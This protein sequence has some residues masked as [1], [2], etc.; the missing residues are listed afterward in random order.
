[1]AHDI[2][3]PRTKKYTKFKTFL[4][5]L[6]FLIKKFFYFFIIFINFIFHYKKKKIIDIQDYI[7]DTRF[8]NYLFYS[9]K[10]NYCFSYN[11]SFTLVNFVKKIGIKNFI[12]HSVPNILL[13]KKK[14]IKFLVNSNDK[15]IDAIN[16]N[17]N[18]FGNK[19]DK[20]FFYM[21]YYMYPKIYNNKYSEIEKLKKN[22]KTIRILFSG[23]TNEEVY[24]KF[25][26]KYSD[27][28]RLLNRVEI[29]NYIID[30]FKDKVY[31]LKNYTDIK[32]IDFF[33]KKIVLSINNKL[34]KKSNTNLTTNEHLDLI[35][36]SNFF[37]TAP[38]GDMPLCHHLIESIKLKSIPISNYAH[39]HKPDLDI[40]NYIQFND[41][42]SLKL[43][44]ES[45][46]EM[47]DIEII[48]KQKNL[49]NFYDNLL[50]P[51]S[52]SDKFENYLSNEIISCNDIESLKWLN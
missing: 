24:S 21:P 9:L 43:A 5:K 12:L 38:G 28:S 51:K 42:N 10:D 32:K 35:S 47:T 11:L 22:K 40:K 41:F 4:I 20:G 33:D 39:L 34:I 25:N 1:M 45:A 16:F 37:L 46:I 29:I 23:S 13:R 27:D 44:I 8:I 50:S 14:K 19:T 18:Y 17:T 7:I 26:W 36:R 6:E 49:E 31:L 52:F 3:N 2:E 48:A 15:L 30:T